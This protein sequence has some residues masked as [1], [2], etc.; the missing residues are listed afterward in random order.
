MPVDFHEGLLV[1]SAVVE[2]DGLVI[3]EDLEQPPAIVAPQGLEDG[4][5]AQMEA[6][7]EVRRDRAEV[8]AVERVQL[9]AVEAAL[10]AEVP[11]LGPVVVEDLQIA[12]AGAD[13][14]KAFHELCQSA[15]RG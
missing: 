7:D 11:G 10:R 6:D 14:E 12:G 2:R 1:R 15:E 4:V 13:V 9:I 5:E 3:A 8:V